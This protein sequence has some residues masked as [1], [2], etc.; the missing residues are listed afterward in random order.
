LFENREDVRRK[1]KASLSEKIGKIALYKQEFTMRD[2]TR[3]NV[4]STVLPDDKRVTDI[5]NIETS[6][7]LTRFGGLNKRRQLALG[8][9]GIESTFVSVPQNLLHIGSIEENAYHQLSIARETAEQFERDPDWVFINGISRGAMTGLAAAAIASR[10]NMGVMYG[11][12]IVPCFP[13][14]LNP[15][16]DLR[17]LPDLITNEL[18]P[19]RSLKQIPWK[20]LRHYPHTIDR[21]PRQLLQQLKEVPTLLSGTVGELIDDSLPPEAFGYITAYEGDIMSQ[22]R[23]WQEKFHPAMYPNMI[24]D[25]QQGGGHLSCATVP[26]HDGWLDRMKSVSDVVGRYEGVLK[27]LG[28]SDGPTKLYDILMTESEAFDGREAI[29]A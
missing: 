18:D 24:V 12:Y 11:D 27:A 6:A 15:Q 23:R 17:E 26:C 5:A 3:Y 20:A 8:K 16:E 1:T 29:A 7:W 14:G 25:L 28:P 13:R 10:H 19:I 9:M 4:A 21:L 22:G 2:G